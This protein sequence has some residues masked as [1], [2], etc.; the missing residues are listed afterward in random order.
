MLPDRSVI[1]T[2]SESLGII[3]G[4]VVVDD[5]VV[6]EVVVDEDVMEEEDAVVLVVVEV[7]VLEVEGALGATTV[8]VQYPLGAFFRTE[9]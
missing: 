7:V 6:V 2:T 3:Y 4:I 8:K 1:R 5:V 9:P